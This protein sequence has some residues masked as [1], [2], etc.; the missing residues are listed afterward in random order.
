MNATPVITPALLL[1]IAAADVRAAACGEHSDF[2]VRSDPLLAPVRPA[3]CAHVS[4]TP[5]EFTWPPQ[6]TL[7]D[8]E[9][10]LIFPD[11][12][13]VTRTTSHNWLLWDYPLPPG[14]YRWRVVSLGEPVYKS[15][16]RRFSIA[17]DA[18][19]FVVPQPQE[20]LKRAVNTPR[21][22]T[23][24]SRTRSGASAAALG[25]SAGWPA[26]V[27]EVNSKLTTPV[28]PEPKSTSIG[29][30]YDEAVAEQ[31][32][33]LSAALAWAVTRDPKY[34]GDAMRRLLAQARWNPSGTTSYEANDMAN[35]AVAWTLALGYDWIHDFLAPE[36][37][38]ILADAIRARTQP[39]FED[40]VPRLGRY[41]Y[42]SHGNVTLTAVAA[43]GVLMAGDLPEAEDWMAGALPLAAV[44]TSPWG[45]PD[46]GFANG[47][48]QMLWDT[49]SHLPA[50]YVLR[51]AAGVDFARKEW[52]RNH[53][54]FMAYF[55]PPGAPG[56]L[57]G[58]GHEM[59]LSETAARV[60][61]ALARF[62]PD[63]LARW[64]A[65]A[66]PGEDGGRIEL[67]LAPKMDLGSGGVPAG[68][69]DAAAFPSVGW[70]A[71]HS[72]LS[73]PQRTSVYFKSSPYGS[74]N[75]SHADQNSFVI[76]HKGERLAMSTG[77]YDGYRTPHWEGWYKQTRAANAITF[78]GGQGQ[79]LNGK[80]Y[81]G[82]IV[83]F[84]HHAAYDYAIGRA[85]KAY[86]GAL[87]RA[88]RSIVYLRPDMVV[89]HDMLASDVPRTWEWNIHAAERFAVASPTAIAVRRGRSRMCVEM[90]AGPESRFDQTDAFAVPPA[91]K[92][93]RQWHGAFKTVEKST[94]AQFIML[95]R[96][97]AD[98][99]GAR[100][101]KAAAIE[102]GWTVQAGNS[103]VTLTGDRVAVETATL[104]AR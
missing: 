64:N 21:P 102:G 40:V 45:G 96:I 103:T 80:Q 57:F 68:T 8:Y 66:M 48:A 62:A 32:R 14:S 13:V 67:I 16:E 86:G 78:D 33:T 30:N 61:K 59:D 88:Q 81:S 15:A 53:G 100:S 98:C 6:D 73:H 70:V 82:E 87:T 92:P 95:M 37:R 76:D 54:R 41:P 89:V 43:I 27:A 11:G 25:Q 60:A 31:K 9:V 39:M 22:R 34:G 84:E 97:G 42:D 69:P 17:A 10:S 46:G 77:A 49:G 7:H 99:R 24:S 28:Q 4:Q 93:P 47:T 36:Q 65:R 101:G 20:L 2:M 75:H 44:W 35:R 74:Y 85:E 19:T 50:W 79:G 52:V 12:S 94:Q 72:R 5:P 1:A 26:L 55:S 71:M 3:D 38:A 23:W 56:G 29:S 18:A 51:N 63:P 91:G 104:A 58:D 83:R 90:L